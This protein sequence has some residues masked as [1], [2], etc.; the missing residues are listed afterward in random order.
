MVL[1]RGLSLRMLP[2]NSAPFKSMF[3][4]CDSHS[5]P[6]I[7]TQ[8]ATHFA[9]QDSMGGKGECWV[10]INPQY[11]KVGPATN[12]DGKDSEGRIYGKQ[13]SNAVYKVEWN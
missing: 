9:L 2:C 10:G 5:V 13:W 4:C 8:N 11:D 1:G 12:C 7:I 6:T 3:L